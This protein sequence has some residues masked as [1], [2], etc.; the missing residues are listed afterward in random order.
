MN[1]EMWDVRFY[2]PG[3][4]RK[5]LEDGIDESYGRWASGYSITE[6]VRDIAFDV[7]SLELVRDLLTHL[8]EDGW[9]EIRHKQVDKQ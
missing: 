8:P 7:P 9:A 3:T 1:E 4:V 6:E 2:Y 5:E